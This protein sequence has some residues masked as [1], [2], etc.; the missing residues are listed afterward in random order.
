MKKYHKTFGPQMLAL[1]SFLHQLRALLNA[2]G[3]MKEVERIDRALEL[4]GRRRP[5]RMGGHQYFFQKSFEDLLGLRE[6]VVQTEERNLLFATAFAQYQA[7]PRDE[8]QRIEQDARTVARRRECELEDRVVALKKERRD[9][10]A[11]Q[12]RQ[13]EQE[14]GL[15]R[16]GKMRLN[17]ERLRQLYNAYADVKQLTEKAVTDQLAEQTAPPDLPRREEAVAICNYP[18]PSTTQ[19]WPEAAIW[20]KHLAAN[21][22]VVKYVVLLSRLPGSLGL[23]HLVLYF[24]QNPVYGVLVQVWRVDELPAG[25][26]VNH[27]PV[28]RG[29]VFWFLGHWANR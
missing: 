28:T 13:G 24:V 17:E 20:V 8:Q 19:P 6:D 16:L 21:R 2:E 18:N 5:G 29:G 9:L 15:A 3:E 7:L 25:S 12:K 22:L 26:V 14:V 1:R 11:E 23:S 10:M 27:S 4:I